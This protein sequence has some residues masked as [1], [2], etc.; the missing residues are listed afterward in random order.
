MQSA[1]LV[2]MGS[3]ATFVVRKFI[4]PDPSSN[5]LVSAAAARPVAQR[6]GSA[7]QSSDGN[8]KHDGYKPRLLQYRSTLRLSQCSKPRTTYHR[9]SRHCDC[10][11]Q[12]H[13]SAIFSRSLWHLYLLV[14]SSQ[15]HQF[16]SVLQGCPKPRLC[17][18]LSLL[19]SLKPNAQ[20][21]YPY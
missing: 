15:A 16:H 7:H 3:K 8:P 2:S 20:M 14:L 4:G 1:A 5:W 13:P 19:L 18:H 11:P 9:F 6:N 21:P 17:Q 10:K 12:S